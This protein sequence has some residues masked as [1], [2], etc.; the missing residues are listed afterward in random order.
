MPHR[1]AEPQDV[2]LVTLRDHGAQHGA[3]VRLAVGDNHHDLGGAWPSPSSRRV[4]SVS[5]AEQTEGSLP[6]RAFQRA[7]SLDLQPL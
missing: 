5:V 1:D 4:S 7:L 2:V 6:V 3:V